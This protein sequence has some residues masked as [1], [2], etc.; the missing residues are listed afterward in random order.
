MLSVYMD[1]IVSPDNGG[2]TILSYSLELDDGMNGDFRIITGFE[3]LNSL[4]LY[5]TLYT[6]QISTGM[7]YR[8]RY[9]VKNSIGW[10]DYSP[11]AYILVAGVPDKNPNVQVVSFSSSS[12]TLQ[13]SLPNSN[14]AI[15]TS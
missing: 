8:A 13:F 9:R 4:K 6:P 3:N 1:A 14:G 11:I 10:S 5:V 7:T 15:I 2:S 12:L